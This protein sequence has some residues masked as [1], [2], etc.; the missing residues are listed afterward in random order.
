MIS[1]YLEAKAEKILIDLGLMSLPID[2]K[3]C[4]EKMAVIVSPADLGADVS[5]IFVLKNGTAHIGYKAD[6]GENRIRFTIAH[7]LGHFVLH[8]KEKPLFVDKTQLAFHRDTNS[9]SGEL[10]HEREA[11]AFAAALLMPK[12]L[13]EQELKNSPDRPISELANKFKVSTQAMTI[14]L[15][16]LGLIDYDG[17]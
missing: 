8:S 6:D 9:S 10:R 1:R 16:N 7:E 15:T 2:I 12:R 11:N 13:I 4:A 14:R 17:H 3:T 5:G